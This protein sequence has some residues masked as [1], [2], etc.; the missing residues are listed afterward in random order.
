MKNEN[1]KRKQEKNETPP[2]KVLALETC[3]PVEHAYHLRHWFPAFD[4]WYRN[5]SGLC[6][7]LSDTIKTRTSPGDAFCM[8]VDSEEGLRDLVCAFNSMPRPKFIAYVPHALE[9]TD[10]YK[11]AFY[12]AGIVIDTK[13]FIASPGMEGKRWKT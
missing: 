13:V 12:Y 5:P 8:I 4:K 6:I 10:A 7:V 2:R 11:Q 3:W 9:Q 1:K